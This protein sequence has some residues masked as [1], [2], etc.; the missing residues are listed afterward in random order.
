MKIFII[1]ILNI[2][3]IQFYG[4]AS[5]VNEE[6]AK[7]VARNFK[8][9]TSET[10][11]NDISKLQKI[12]S[13]SYKN[14]VTFYTIIYNNNDWVMISAHDNVYPVLAFSDNGS[15]GVD[16][17]DPC[18][19]WISFYFDKFIYSMVKHNKYEKNSTQI[20]D[21]LLN[22]NID[23]KDVSSNYPDVQ[24]ILSTY[25]GQEQTNDNEYIPAYNYYMPQTPD[26]L[27]CNTENCPAGCVAVALGQIM[28]YWEQ[29]KCS[30]FTWCNMP[31]YINY[32]ENSNL[33]QQNENYNEERNAVSA[34]LYYIGKLVD[35]NYCRY[36]T[37]A[38]GA[39]NNDALSALQN[40]LG[41]VNSTLVSMDDFNYNEWI[42]IIRS[43]ILQDYPVY[44]T[45]CEIPNNI[46]HAFVMDGY[47]NI[48]LLGS[49]M[50]LFH[51]NWGWNGD[52]NGY[53]RITN[54]DPTLISFNYTNHAIIDIS[55]V[56]CNDEFTI[57]Q[58]LNEENPDLY[59]QPVAGN[60][61]SSPNSISIGAEE[62]V[63]Y[64]A[65]NKIVLE[66]FET[67]DGA[68]FTAE[69]IPCPVNCDFGVQPPVAKSSKLDDFNHNVNSE[70]KIALFPNPA[71]NNIK[72]KIQKYKE[73][74][75][76]E[77]V[78]YNCYGDKILNRKIMN[79]K[80]N[81]NIK[82]FSPGIYFMQ[83]I[84]NNTTYLQKF[85]KL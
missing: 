55:P 21:R 28:K 71:K 48:P 63:H 32:W 61:Y 50:D 42:D 27:H 11:F 5:F 4:Y 77:L 38:S 45:G 73:E 2:I 13:N 44:Y 8:I 31:D 66:N 1:L 41:Y 35:M 30:Q 53:Y 67:E 75:F 76:D 60:I 37:C 51:V 72:I 83:I 33:N 69:I 68:N 84:S 19:Q 15:Y 12:E 17:P 16:M 82:D 54:L 80:L 20:W 14:T 43:Q 24:P 34:L 36:N 26:G 6:D 74:N 78:I 58:E 81:I 18:Q 22:D 39:I 7:K 56:D 59:Y 25:W 29:P 23:K 46:C 57:Y 64:R 65:Y 85:I 3:I 10:Y 52:D 47:C 70:T 40:F 79:S 9:Y 49:N 62:N